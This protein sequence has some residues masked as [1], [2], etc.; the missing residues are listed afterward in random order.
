MLLVATVAALAWANSPASASYEEL[1]HTKISIE[2]GGAELVSL[3]LRHWINDLLMALFFFVVGIEIKRELV[4]GELNAPRRAAL[5]AAAALG[6]MVIPALV[7]LSLNWGGPGSI[8]WGIP[9]ATD[10]AFAVGVLALFGPRVPHALK[11]LLL[12][13]A[14]VDD[15]G[16]ILVIALV[17]SGDIQLV[18]LGLAALFL[19]GIVIL[20]RIPSFWT[21]PPLVALMVAVWVATFASGIHATIAGVALGLVAPV[22][23]GDPAPGERLLKTLH[24]WTSLLIVPLFALA[25]AGLRL[26]PGAFVDAAVSPVGLGVAAG[27]VLGKLAGISA[28]SWLAVRSGIATLPEQVTWSQLVGVAAVAGIGF[29]VSLFITSL[30]FP[31]GELEAAAKVGILAGSLVAAVVGAV[32][33]SRSL[34]SRGVS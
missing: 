13:I 14:I 34:P 15:I 25:N 12:S 26:D 7:F 1:W 23:G 3:D 11:V 24:P 19:V 22:R 31:S 17:Y 28:A 18:P 21:D 5:P 6:G 32:L 20:W 4:D 30:A 16:A 9:M 8:G 10:I 27:L 2:V 33:L 29:T